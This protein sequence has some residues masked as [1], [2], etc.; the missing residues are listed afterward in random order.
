MDWPSLRWPETSRHELR[1]AELLF[2]PHWG[3]P[4]LG[5]RAAGIVLGPSRGDELAGAI[6]RVE[7]V[8]VEAFVARAAVEDS[9][10]ALSLG[11]PRVCLRPEPANDAG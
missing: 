6:Q 9:M 7:P 3:E 5:P 1:L 11:L 10:K 8:G 4:A 2:V